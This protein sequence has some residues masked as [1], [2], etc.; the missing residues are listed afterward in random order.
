MVTTYCVVSIKGLSSG[1]VPAA[2]N[3]SAYSES[4]AVTHAL[5]CRGVVLPIT[6]ISGCDGPPGS[7]TGHRI[8]VSTAAE[9][10]LQ[11]D[12]RR[13]LL[14]A[15]ALHRSF[16]SSAATTLVKSWAPYFRRH[17]IHPAMLAT[18]CWARRVRIPGGSH[19]VAGGTMH[20]FAIS[21]PIRCAPYCRSQCPW[22]S[23]A[24]C[25]TA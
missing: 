15:V 3:K 17:P 25:S 8:V 1:L 12:E 7:L 16:C 9:R 18:A 10:V 6:T 24:I 11:P 19:D 13:D 2:C 23:F 22:G 14:C 21:G 4:S 5:I 20:R